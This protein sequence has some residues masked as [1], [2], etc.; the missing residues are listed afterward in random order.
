MKKPSLIAL[1]AII[2]VANALAVAHAFRNRH[3]ATPEAKVT[4]TQRELR[5]LN[6]S[7]TD[8]SGVTLQLA[9]MDP[10]NSPWADLVENPAIWLDQSRL[11]RLGF[12]CSVNP[13][14]PDAERYYQ[15]QRPRQVFIALE[16]EGAAWRAWREAYERAVTAQTG[17]MRFNLLAGT[18]SYR[19]HLIAI[20]ADLNPLKLRERYPDRAAFIILPAVVA[21][22]LQ[23]FP[24]QG[25]KLD[26]KRPARVVGRIEQ[27]PSSIHVPRPFSDEFRRLSQPQK[28][29]FDKDLLY[30][31]HLCYGASFEPW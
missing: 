20:D 30:R 6:H 8:D 12:D 13:S 17:K 19:S 21:A 5:Y 4:L 2:V 3:V 9:W 29:A 27:L 11:E 31:V 14:S 24:S 26:P 22:T 16:Y 10:N 23:P 25:M 18:E 1:A 28:R 15:R 7:A